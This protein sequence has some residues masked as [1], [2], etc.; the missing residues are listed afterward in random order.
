MLMQQGVGGGQQEGQKQIMIITV[1]RV[2]RKGPSLRRL[3][4]RKRVRGIVLGHSHHRHAAKVAMLHALTM[5]GEE[6]AKEA[7]KRI[8]DN[9]PRMTINVAA[10][11]WHAMGIEECAQGLPLHDTTQRTNLIGLPAP[12]EHRIRNYQKSFSV[13]SQSE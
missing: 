10:D 6:E 3:Q 1:P 13:L 5:Q 8:V 11:R 12:G 7:T 4:G 9:P 2:G